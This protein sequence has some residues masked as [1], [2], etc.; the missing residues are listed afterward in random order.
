ML[1]QRTGV[2][3]NPYKFNTKELD[4]ETG[5][6]YYGARYY[7]PRA[8]IW[9]G[10]EPLAVYNPAMETQFYG[11]GQHNGGVY[12][13]GNLNPYIYTY[14]NPI[15]YIDPNGKQV[16]AIKRTQSYSLKAKTPEANFRMNPNSQQFS[17]DQ[18]KQIK[19]IPAKFMLGVGAENTVV[20]GG[21]LEQVKN[22]RSVIKTQE[23]L[24][25]QAFSDGKFKKGETQG[26]WFDI[27]T[28]PGANFSRIATN[29]LGDLL[30]GKSFDDNEFFQGE[31]VLGSFWMT[32]RMNDDGKNVTLSV[33]DTKSVGSLTDGLLKR[34][35]N[36]SS[37]RKPFSKTYQAYIWQK[38]LKDVAI[39]AYKPSKH[40]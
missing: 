2:Y 6:Y 19:N 20:T 25:K 8:S 11:D 33:F 14:Q 4:K 3:N 10:V 35:D 26:A 38:S 15:K 16:D 12:F 1:E 36:K 13:W 24:L 40:K 9:Y 29:S 32:M 30:G 28:I 23:L 7:N 27:G 17:I 18:T 22:A 37:A 5:L 39:E 34:Q 31:N 21:A